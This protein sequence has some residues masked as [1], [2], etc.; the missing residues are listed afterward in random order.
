MQEEARRRVALITGA[1]SPLGIG[2]ATAMVLGREG[3]SLAI[4]S[5]TGRIHER[6]AELAA[7]GYEV[8][9][10]EADLTDPTQARALA[11]A[12]FEMCTLGTDTALLRNVAR[13]ELALA[14]Q[15]REAPAEAPATPYG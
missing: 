3:A 1:G 9:G 14:R 12:G 10:F 8:A 4:S 15:T 6:A 2:F 5:T 11:D 7:A 13:S